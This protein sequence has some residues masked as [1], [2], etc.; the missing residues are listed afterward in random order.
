MMV[1][2]SPIFVD[3]NIPMYTVGKEHPLKAGCRQAM[4]RISDEV[5]DAVTDVEVHQ[6]IMHRYLSLKMPAQARQVSSDFQ[7][8]VSEVLPI[9]LTDL[10]RARELSMNYPTL[11][12]RDLLHLAV[13]LNHGLTRILS[14]DAHF[15]V[16]GEIERI[17]PE[18]FIS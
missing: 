1:K 15:D 11:D 5:I 10:T 7:E 12:A 18:R 9:T 17:P 2:N 6:E 3:A 8:V 4:V 14:T 13:M 16:I